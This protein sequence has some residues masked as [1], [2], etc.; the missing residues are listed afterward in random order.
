MKTL[1]LGILIASLMPLLCS[2]ER[3]EM[4]FVWKGKDYDVKGSASSGQ[5]WM[6]VEYTVQRGKGSVMIARR[7]R[8]PDARIVLASNPTRSAQ[9][10]ARELQHYIEKITGVRLP[11]TTDHTT[12]FKG[13]KILVG[14]S[15]LTRVLGLKKED[16][17][18][19]EYLIRTYGNILVLMGYDEPEYG[20]TDYEGTGLWHN[21]TNFYDWSLKPE[22][23]KKIGSV[24]AV[25]TFL[26]MFC[27]VRWYMPGEIGEVVPQKDIVTVR[28]LDIKRKPW[29]T[30]RAIYPPGILEPFHFIGSGRKRL[31]IP[32]RELHLW[33]MRM[34]LVGVEAFNANHSLIAPWFQKR[35]PD[36]KEI[37]AKGYEHPTQLCLSSPQLLKIVLKDA[38]DYFAGKANYERSLGNYFCVMPHDTQQYCKCSECQK[39]IKSEEEAGGYG[40]WSD[41]SSNYVWGLVNRVAIELKKK[42]P[43]KWVSCCSYAR[44]TLPPDNIKLSDNIAVMLCRVLVDGIKDPNYKKFYREEQIGKW[45]GLVKRWYIW[46]YFDHIQGNYQGSS[47]PGI[48]LHEIAEDIQFLKERACRGM[49]NELSSAGGVLPNIAQDHLNLYVQLKLLE[50]ASLDV[51]AMLDEYC[52]LFYGPASEPMKKFFVKME[53]RFTNPDNWKLRGEE[54]DPNWDRICD[55]RILEE[56][57][58]L[59]EQ[60]LGLAE[61][62]PYYSRVRLIKEAVFDVMEKNC[63][64]HF[65]L[66]KS[67]KRKLKV[68]RIKNENDLLHSKGNHIEEFRSIA[69]D[70]VKTK[71]E[72]WVGY[73]SEHLYVKVK[74][75]EE[76]MDKLRAVVKPADEDKMLICVDDSVELFIDIGRTRKDYYQIL[77]NTNG[78]VNDQKRFGGRSDFSFS[79][80]TAVRVEKARDHWS[81]T[82]KVPIK[83]LTGGRPVKKGEVWGFN[84]CRNRHTPSKGISACERF[85]AWC[86]TGLSFHRPER[87][88]IIEFE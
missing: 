5:Y 17:Q 9:I 55:P 28:D 87:F 77:A 83:P 25:D 42:Y 21:F 67:T 50:D 16:F 75:Y 78:A 18:P 63:M 46:E 2:G 4:K 81:I 58:K 22:R 64:R 60:A 53:E 76:F 26:E 86:P 57:R 70:P 47:F 59:I 61:E 31:R 13:P 73:D 23:C 51:D 29:T 54:T 1:P 40:W 43:D 41:R 84:V 80:G 62:E 85:T 37:L 12:P 68:P 88:G 3:E 34:K 20:L 72:A 49:F 65:V 48:F 79:T 45:S 36:N 11:I 69:G 6:K 56:F 15:K 44:Y 38:E 14:E 10:A 74:C 52:K 39:L 27:G 33:L 24:Y 71:T 19:Q 82:L 35:F 32:A 8:K 30:F 66:M 7:G